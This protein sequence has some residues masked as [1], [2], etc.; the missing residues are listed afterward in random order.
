MNRFE[1]SSGLT[2]DRPPRRYLW[3]DAHAVCNYLGLS[4]ATGDET[5]R[6]LAVALVAQVHEVLGRHRDDDERSGWISGLDDTEGRRHPT[7][8]GLRIGKPL[9]ERRSDEPQ[10]PRAEWDQD[11]QYYHYLTKWMHALRQL[12]A[13]TGEQRYLTWAQELAVAAHAAFRARSGPAR[14]YWKMSIDLSRP[15]VPSSGLHDPL[16]GLVT[17]LTLRVGGAD[18]R[19]LEPIVD[20]LSAMCRG[21]SWT[22]DDPLGI[23]GLLFDA[24]RLA[25]LAP[26][27]RRDVDPDL[28]G[29][30]LED[31]DSGITAFSRSRTLSEPAANRLAF[32]ELGLC[33]GLQAPA[34]IDPSSWPSPIRVSVERLLSHRKLGVSIERFWSDPRTRDNATW[35]EHQ[36]IN[37]VMLATSLV[38]GGFLEL[39]PVGPIG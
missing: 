21:R 15:L 4:E 33:I 12:S 32:R 13:A 28:L 39:A 31:A 17:A 35:R 10:D 30:V 38:P 20:D 8:G 7:I 14:L 26:D 19:E 29:T 2:G 11:G 23:G 5:W 36:D 18:D 1:R 37:E 9:P 27:G 22:T 6:Q 34:R 3:T 24:G 16:D 25:Q